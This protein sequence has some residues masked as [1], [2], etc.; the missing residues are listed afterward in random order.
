MCLSPRTVLNKK[1]GQYGEVPCGSCPVCRKRRAAHWAFRL[2][3]EERICDSAHFVT[4]TYDTDHVPITR[5]GYLNLCKR[6]VQLYMKKVRKRLPGKKVKYYCAGEY[7]EKNWR[8]HYH[9][10]MFNATEDSIIDAWDQGNVWIGKVEPASVAYT[11]KY[12]CK[13]Q[14]AGYRPGDDRQKEFSVMSKRL[15]ANYLSR[16]MLAWHLADV[17]N[18]VYCNLFDGMKVSMPRYYRERIYSEVQRLR[19][20]QVNRQRYIE[21]EAKEA[22]ADP[23]YFVNRQKAVKAAFYAA[24]VADLNKGGKL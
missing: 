19:I 7:G 11:L 15:G 8:P 21:K 6:D 14:R 9:I 4:L 16:D 12:I 22:A 2:G 5:N 13:V 1:T 18:R 3:Q 20:G 10:I 24:Y 23:D 17:E